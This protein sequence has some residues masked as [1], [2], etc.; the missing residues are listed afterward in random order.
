MTTVAAVEDSS[1]LAPEVA[2]CWGMVA[3]L[4][5]LCLRA[6]TCFTVA[7]QLRRMAAEPM[8]GGLCGMLTTIAVLFIRCEGQVNPTPLPS[9]PHEMLYKDGMGR[10]GLAQCRRQ[11]HQQGVNNEAVL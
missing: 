6:C 3:V 4:A 10:R 1:C 9:F 5:R 8:L 11:W 2:V 7:A